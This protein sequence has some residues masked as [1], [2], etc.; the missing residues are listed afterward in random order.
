MTHWDMYWFTRLDYL[1]G[2]GI[3]MA[4]AL[5]V[6]LVFW[7]IFEFVEGETGFRKYRL[8][9]IAAWTFF[10]AIAILTPTQKEAAAIWLVPKMMNNEQLNSIATNT[11]GIL[12]E[13][14][15]QYLGELVAEEEK[16]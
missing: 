15:K 1:Q 16:Q 12:E 13:Q 9:L 2:F 3:S 5:G 14:T 10:L 7:A 6:V 4:M 8:K 11:L